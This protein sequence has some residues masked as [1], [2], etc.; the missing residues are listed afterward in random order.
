MRFLKTVII[1]S[2]CITGFLINYASAEDN[3]VALS[4]Q[5]MDS[6]CG[7]SVYP[8]LEK[9]ADKYFED[10]KYNEYSDFINSLLKQ[11]EA[12]PVLNYNAALAR[13]NQL[14][15][16][17]ESQGWD[18]YFA[19]GNDY[20]DQIVDN[21]SKAV[22]AVPVQDALGVRSRLLLW[23]FHRDQQDAFHEEALDGLIKGITEYAH[24]G[25]D[26]DLIKE[27]A[28]TI[29]SYG[30]KGRSK[31]VYRLY[32]QK[33][34]GG[35]VKLED[36]KQVALS[37]YNEGNLDLAESLFD[38]YI[39]KSLDS[40]PKEKTIPELLEIATLFSYKDSGQKDPVYAEKIFAKAESTGGKEALGEEQIYLRAFNLEKSKDWRGAGD[41]YASLVERFSES[42][43]VNRAIFKLGI[44]HTYILRDKERGTEYFVKLTEKNGAGP[45]GVSSLYQ[46]G[47]LNQWQGESAKAKA[48][49]NKLI[50]KAQDSFNETKSL[51]NLR[52]KEIEE[53]RS[54]DSNLAAFMDNALKEENAQFD[55][56]RVSISA[57]PY[58]ANRDSEILVNSSA[59]SGASGCMQVELQYLWSGDLGA[60]LVQ[61]A[62]ANFNTS[63]RDPGT[64]VINLLV[65]VP[66]GTLDRALDFADIE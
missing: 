6:K 22:G 7:L 11:I 9:T 34:T 49:Y 21:L 32:V 1:L 61:S 45:E 13:F 35:E 15:Y 65:L 31:E 4:K 52:L 26:A 40:S 56:S 29:S 8:A 53:G 60:N 19:K 17:E 10:H 25:Q 47:L 54:L 46:L 2:A 28:D 33:L 58:T 39:E 64:K 20:R 36:L 30:E 23:Q 16:L 3:L 66:S 44:I 55:M 42:K 51:T 24:S 59:L 48:Y 57:S 43:Y 37:F 5:I 63:Y 50:E 12:C 14:K 38:A 41:A 27:V 18:E 62:Q